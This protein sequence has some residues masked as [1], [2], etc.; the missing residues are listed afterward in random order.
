MANNRLW[1]I[2]ISQFECSSAYRQPNGCLQYHTGNSGR[3][4]TFNYGATGVVPDLIQHLPNQQYNICIRQELGQCC[5][6]YSVCM[7]M[8]AG[9]NAMSLGL[10]AMAG[11]NVAGV[12]TDCATDFLSIEAASATC[13]NGV[14]GS[15]LG[16]VATRFAADSSTLNRKL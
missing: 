14:G 5:I 4:E 9:M 15:F 8:T 11:N 16:D 10:L 1:E 7:D 13:Y 3:I 2:K 12:D 6:Q